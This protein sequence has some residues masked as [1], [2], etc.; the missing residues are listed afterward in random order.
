MRRPGSRKWPGLRLGT[1]RLRISM[2]GAYLRFCGALQNRKGINSFGLRPLPPPG[3]SV[4]V[5]NGALNM[6]PA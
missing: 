1:A 2:D 4:R 3:T 5:T 6:G